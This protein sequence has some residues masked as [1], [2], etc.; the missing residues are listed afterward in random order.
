MVVTA[1]TTSPHLAELTSPEVAGRDAAELV[2]VIPLGST[3][4]HGPHLPLS[5]DTDLAAALCERLAD[6][7]SDV[8]IAPTVAY[9]AS[10]EHAGFAGTLS[11]G[12]AALE[13]LIV[14]LVRSATDTFGRVL[15]VS[16]HGGNATAVSNAVD[17]LVAESRD[18]QSFA[19]AWSGD[20][21][22]GRSETSMLLSLAPGRV[23]TD[24]V[25]VGN[26]SSFDE[27]WPT[28]RLDGVRAVSETGVLGDPT[29]A[30]AAEGHALLAEL[31]RQLA[32]QVEHWY[33]ASVEASA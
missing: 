22:A 17:R 5:T 33:D 9:G 30:T 11:I 2:L 26:T 12:T 18:V 25:V 28:L 16:A 24:R 20:L 4:Q 31:V 8:V 3:E 27:L 13:L 19:P 7:R 32:D 21:H 10:G 15:L 1:G 14:E 23:R 29:T 6:L